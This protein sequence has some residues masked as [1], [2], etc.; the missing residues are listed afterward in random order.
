M[1]VT[2]L[3]TGTSQGIP[4]IGC[5][6]PVCRS[7]DDRDQ[8]LLSSLLIEEEGKS[9]VI[10]AGPDFLQ[11][12]LR[13][14][15]EHLDAILLTHEHNDHVIGLDEV[16][17]FNFRQGRHLPVYGTS[18]VLREVMARF[19][20]IFEQ[21]PYPGAPK[22]ELV[23]IERGRPF[24]AAGLRF[25]PFEVL[26]GQWPVMGFRRRKFTYI[27]DMKTIDQDGL[28][29]I[30]GT[31]VLVLNALQQTPHPSHLHLQEALELI[32]NIRPRAA[33]LTHISHGMGLHTMV[34]AQLPPTVHL[35]YDGLRVHL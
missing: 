2:F 22:I 1:T 23:P 4:V 24:L 33:Y 30:Q 7:G 34:T 19:S 14:R 11:Q 16:R 21:K 27:T 8:R 17:P 29:A 32:D 20:Y 26:H 10:D 35:A 12:M 25:I 31:E 6:C 28:N 13:A 18:R 15:V 3:G 9:V 5:D